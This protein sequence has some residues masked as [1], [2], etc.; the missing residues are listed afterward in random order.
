MERTRYNRQRSKGMARRVMAQP[1]RRWR[2]ETVAGAVIAAHIVRHV[3][4]CDLL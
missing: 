4:W 2:A 3:V 1:L